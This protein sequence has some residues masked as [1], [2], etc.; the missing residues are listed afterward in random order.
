MTTYSKGAPFYNALTTIARTRLTACFPQGI[1]L[2]AVRCTFLPLQR[3]GQEFGP[4]FRFTFCS[5]F[6]LLCIGGIADE[7]PTRLEKHLRC[8]SVL[9]RD[10]DWLA[11][12][13]VHNVAEL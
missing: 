4:V 5:L 9:C 8:T 3:R 2:V 6:S 7:E 11:C 12:A 10:G 13:D 1:I